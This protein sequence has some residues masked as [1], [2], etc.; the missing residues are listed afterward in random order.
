[1]RR[2]VQYPASTHYSDITISPQWHQ[3]LRHTRLDP[4]SLTE[5]SQDLVR[6]Q[7]LKILAA[8]ADARWAAKPSF[9]DA[10]GQARGQR[11]PALEVEQPNGNANL[12]D[13][14]NAVPTRNSIGC[15][16][17]DLDKKTAILADTREKEGHIIQDANGTGHRTRETPGQETRSQVESKNDKK[18]LWKHAHR[19]EKWQPATWDGNVAGRR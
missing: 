4:P 3:W 12:T 9:L 1:M 17:E 14:Q 10:P 11:V 5:Q 6:Q 15:G 7:N 8:E 13:S 19:G 18:D 16:L 2:I